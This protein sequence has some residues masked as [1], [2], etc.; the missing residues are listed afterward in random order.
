[1]THL[2]TLAEVDVLPA[3]CNDTGSTALP[4]D[5]VMPC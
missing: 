2:Q 4:C 3:V 1:M 5:D